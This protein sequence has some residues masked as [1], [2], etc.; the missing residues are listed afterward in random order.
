MNPM[1]LRRL[2]L[3]AAALALLSACSLH[4][5]SC[6]LPTN[7]ESQQPADALAAPDLPLTGQPG[8]Q[9]SLLIAFLGDSLT[10]GYGLQFNQ[11]YP[12]VIE[13]MFHDDG[14]GGVGVING[15]VTGDT[16][17]GG[18][19]R[20]EQLLQPNVRVLV[21]ALGGND[22]L[23]GLTTTETH[24]NLAAII[25]GTLDRHVSVVLAGMEA[26]TNLGLDYQ[27]AFHNVFQQLDREYQGAIAFIPFLLEGVAGNPA[28]NQADG[29]HPTA[30]GARHIAQ[31]L[32]PTLRR[33]VEQGQ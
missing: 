33:V 6:R 19:R 10:A 22:A 12:T 13:Q 15:G 14:Y 3:V 11:A 9:A 25:D 26:P 2:A 7:N 28:L 32:Y 21:V 24:D 8:G 1:R 5:V 17:A 16:T 31:L 23:R 30:E 29:I 4:A 18:L 20:A 27:T